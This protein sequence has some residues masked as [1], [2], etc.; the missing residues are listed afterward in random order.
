MRP[1]GERSA[2]PSW[3]H[4]ADLTRFPGPSLSVLSAIVAKSGTKG[5]SALLPTPSH[6]YTLPADV[7]QSL[8]E[9]KQ[10]QPHLKHDVQPHMPMTPRWNETDFSLAGVIA[11]TNPASPETA[12]VDLR[13]FTL[14]LIARYQHVQADSAGS[15]F[16]Q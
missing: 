6:S 16:L 7:A 12:T 2:C 14:Q 5:L 15:S 9:Q 4:S 8:N 11:L 10:E 13:T 3:S 1:S